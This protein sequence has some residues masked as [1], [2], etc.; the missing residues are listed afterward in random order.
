MADRA[1][2][3]AIQ[4]FRDALGMDYLIMS[5]R[6]AAGPAHEEELACIRRFGGDVIPAFR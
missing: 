4:R 2:I 1:Q 3:A 6:M 5:S